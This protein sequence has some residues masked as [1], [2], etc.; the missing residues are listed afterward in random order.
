M[1]SS[2]YG[3]EE[4]IIITSNSNKN[5]LIN[6]KHTQWIKSKL[7]LISIRNQYNCNKSENSYYTNTNSKSKRKDSY[8]FN[9]FRK[10][11]NNR[12]NKLIR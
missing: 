7:I 1:I 4:K 8:N 9:S 2:W 10:N 12:D 3:T 6:L 5:V 11:K